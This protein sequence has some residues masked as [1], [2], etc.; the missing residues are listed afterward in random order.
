MKKYIDANKELWNKRTP[1]HVSSSF[2]DNESFIRGKCSLKDIE[3]NLLGDIKDKK[4]LHLQCHFGQDSISLA[5]LGANVTAID[6]SNVAIDEAIKLSEKTNT[7]VHFICCDVMKMDEYLTDSYDIIFTSYGTIGW[8][9]ELTKW[10]KLIRQFLKPGGQF[11]IV[12]FHPVVWMFSDDFSGVEYSYFNREVIE[13]ESEE[14]YADKASVVPG[15]SYGWNHSFDEVFD[16]LLSQGLK[17]IHFKE[18]ETSP[19][20]SFSN[21]VTVNEG[22][23]IKDMENKL[24]MVY[25]LLVEKR[26]N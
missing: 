2:Y 10:G 7:P 11:L 8:L 19:Y 16:A 12:E 25:S 15:K 20:D 13:T 26:Q 4:I 21:T 17:I 9:P 22:Y 23:Q 5:R 1:I 18:Y 24:P 3:L 14:T 6:L